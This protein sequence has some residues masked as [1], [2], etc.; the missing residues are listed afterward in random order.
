MKSNIA[1]IPSKTSGASRLDIKKI[2]ENINKIKK[3]MI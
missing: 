1:L 2:D 3:L